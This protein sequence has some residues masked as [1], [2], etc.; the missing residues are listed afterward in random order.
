MKTSTS[1]RLRIVGAYLL[2]AVF[3][4][5]TFSA[6]GFKT[7]EALENQLVTGRDPTRATQ[8]T[9]AHK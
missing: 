5:A 3:L 1:L 2:L 7:L 6:I 4:G 8:R 9:T